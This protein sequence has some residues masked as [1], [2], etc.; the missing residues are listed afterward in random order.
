VICKEIATEATIREIK[1][2]TEVDKLMTT[3]LALEGDPR[4]GPLVRLTPP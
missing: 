2:W 1:L 3:M 4:L